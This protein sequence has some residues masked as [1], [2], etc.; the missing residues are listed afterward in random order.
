MSR[1]LSLLFLSTIF[2]ALGASAAPDHPRP[3]VLFIL[4]DDHRADG[5]GALGNPN[6]RTPNLDQLVERGMSFSR[7]YV[8]GSTEGA[9]CQPSR[10]MIQTGRSLYHLPKTNLR[11]SY[12]DFSNAMKDKVEGKDWA[13]MPRVMK[14]AGYATL[15]VGKP[16]NECT[17][18]LESY[19]KNI[20]RPDNSPAER[21]SSSRGHADH[22][23][24]YLRGRIDDKRPF[25]IYLAPP[26]PHDP[27]VAQQEFMDLYDPAKITLP[28][29]YLPVHPFDNG[30]MTVRDEQLA[31]W[32]RP[33]DNIRRQLA[34]YYACIT[35]LDHHLG[36]IFECLKELGQFDNTIIIFAGDNGLSMGE[37][38]L[39]GKQNVY[40]FGG[41]H[42]PLV[43]AGPGVKSGRSDAFVYMFDL[44]PTICDVT[45]TP[46]P[47]AAE[48]RS[49]APVLA[50][51]KMKERDVMFNTYKDVQ[52][53]LRDDRWKIIQYPQINR[54]QLFDLKND[55]YELNDLAAK[56]EAAPRIKKMLASMAKVQK[57]FGDECPLTVAN[58]KPATWTPPAELPA[59]KKK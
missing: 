2:F 38:G 24:E 48:G 23:I 42:V 59:P 37:H 57:E 47:R 43:I 25:F 19:E 1:Q 9:V 39:M 17:P 36:R 13:L 30:E 50:G 20:N 11:K 16:G 45:R 29:A 3:N 41:M 26:V 40:E 4:A 21:A 34:D 8:M 28:R 35:G 27:R 49:L 54:T 7:A 31:R 15:H 18:A 12:T 56:S 22:V 14:D 46:V 52:R 51:K 10:S 44:F 58:P 6:V 5:I 53:S 33:A 32:P 55:P